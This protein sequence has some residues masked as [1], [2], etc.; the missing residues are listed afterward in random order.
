VL[1]KDAASSSEKLVIFDISTLCDTKKTM[2]KPE[3]LKAQELENIYQQRQAILH[4]RNN[5][6]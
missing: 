1:K 5:I 3:I 6:L 4:S 2:D